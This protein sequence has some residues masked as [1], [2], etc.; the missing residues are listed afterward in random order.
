M[1][2][3]GVII[4]LVGLGILFISFFFSS[5]YHAGLNI[6][7][8]IFRMEIVFRDTYSIDAA[9]NLISRI[10]IPLKYPLSFS[11]LLILSGTGIVLVAKN[12]GTN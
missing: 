9:G 4:I 7:G 12:K 5:G 10:A 11:G 3:K 1:K 6:I 2:N 8:N